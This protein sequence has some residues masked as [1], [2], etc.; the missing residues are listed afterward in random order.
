M[1]GKY[2]YGSNM[3]TV[4]FSKTTE[5]IGDGNFFPFLFSMKRVKGTISSFLKMLRKLE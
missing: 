4:L 1:Y 3:L 2:S 5:R